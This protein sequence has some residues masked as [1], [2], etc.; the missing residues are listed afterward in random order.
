MSSPAV[1]RGS[2]AVECT[3][4]E[5]RHRRKPMGVRIPPLQLVVS[6]EIEC[7]TRL[8]AP[9]MRMRQ[10]AMPLASSLDTKPRSSGASIGRSTNSSAS[11]PR[12]KAAQ[13]RSRRPWTWTW[14]SLSRRESNPKR[15]VC[16][17]KMSGLCARPPRSA[18]RKCVDCR[19]TVSGLRVA[20][21]VNRRR[22]RKCQGNEGIWADD[23]SANTAVCRRGWHFDLPAL[24]TRL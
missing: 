13:C 23:R 17:V 6:R 4:L 8:R 19:Q 16:F 15:W 9:S 18:S 14:T 20:L 22:P 11:G 10:K 12:T 3:A 24:P 7:H 21:W 2:R 5:M 1:W